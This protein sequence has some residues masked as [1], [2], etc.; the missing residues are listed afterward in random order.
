MVMMRVCCTCHSNLLS[1]SP[2][3]IEIYVNELK[4]Q[5]IHIKN[6]EKKLRTA[7]TY[8]YISNLL[9][10]SFSHSRSSFLLL[11]FKIILRHLR[12]ENKE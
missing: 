11:S 6:N 1:R 7:A 8:L 4:L 3:K 10:S 2:V 9:D 12:P 5:S